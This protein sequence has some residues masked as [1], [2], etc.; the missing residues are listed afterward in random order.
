[1]TV[2]QPSTRSVPPGALRV[3]V[4]EPL[5]DGTFVVYDDTQVSLV[6]RETL[7]SLLKQ[8]RKEHP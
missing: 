4:F 6:D 7:V 8:L 3:V 2:E 5:A 1:V